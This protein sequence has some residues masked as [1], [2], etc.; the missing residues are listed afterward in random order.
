MG[1]ERSQDKP[2]TE[3]S[4]I[5]PPRPPV[6]EPVDHDYPDGVEFVRADS[7][8]SE[9]GHYTAGGVWIRAI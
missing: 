2:R 7:D 3:V 6:R 5:P 8:S 1:I 9:A 4:D